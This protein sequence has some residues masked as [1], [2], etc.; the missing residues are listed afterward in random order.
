MSTRSS[1]SAIGERS[2]VPSLDRARRSATTRRRRLRARFSDTAVTHAVKDS[3]SSPRSDRSQALAT[4]S[5]TAS[6]AAAR[7]PAIS[8]RPPT[9]LG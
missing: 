2:L 3:I 5:C 7:L 9:S 6:S 8:E 4:A 1:G